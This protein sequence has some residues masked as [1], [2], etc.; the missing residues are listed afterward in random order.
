M[1]FHV[2]AV[3]VMILMPGSSCSKRE[4]AGADVERD[5]RQRMQDKSIPSPDINS[6]DDEVPSD[7]GA[8]KEAGHGIKPG[9]RGGARLDDG[10]Q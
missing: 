6:E 2:V 1:R 7:T 4:P 8:E 9:K 10:P 3:A 5:A